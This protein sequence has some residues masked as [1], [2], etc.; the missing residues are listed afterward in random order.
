MRR[1]ANSDAEIAAA[2]RHFHAPLGT[3]AVLGNH[4][5]W[6][7]A[8]SMRRA[9]RAVGIPVLENRAI[10]A[11]S[12]T[13]VGVGDAFTEHADVARAARQA[14]QLP[15]PTLVF[16]HGPDVVPHLPA[17]F[18]LVLAGHTHCGQIVLPLLGA[19]ATASDYGTR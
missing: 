2:L 4:D 15:G 8:A 13:L 14:A 17:R 16:T 12:L 11:G 1:A 3:Y 19:L 5:H 10:R 9:L 6:R 18:G 7:E